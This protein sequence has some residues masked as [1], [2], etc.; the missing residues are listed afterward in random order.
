[1]AKDV[2]DKLL[3]LKFELED[4]VAVE[5]NDRVNAPLLNILGAISHLE[6]S[7]HTEDNLAGIGTREA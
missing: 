6:S 1:M 4:R 5:T 2:V 3:G 7:L